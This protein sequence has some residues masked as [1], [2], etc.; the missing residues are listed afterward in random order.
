LGERLRTL[1]DSVPPGVR[2]RWPVALVPLGL[3]LAFAWW[4]EPTVRTKPGMLVGQAPKQTALSELESPPPAPWQKE[5]FTV[6]PL[7]RYELQARVL[8]RQRYRSGPESRL[9]PYDLALGWTT[10][11]DQAWIDAVD[12]TQRG[13]WFNFTC[14]EPWVDPEVVLGCAANTHILPATDDVTT[15]LGR[16]RRGD[17]LDLAGWLVQVSDP[18]GWRWTSSLARDDRGGHSC[19]IMWVEKLEVITARF[20]KE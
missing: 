13:R 3:L 5:G 17:V 6:T 14:K 11:S 9:S 2:A 12:V 4:H 7:A 1:I 18:S 20:P 8:S 15:T 19:E 16:V 10:M